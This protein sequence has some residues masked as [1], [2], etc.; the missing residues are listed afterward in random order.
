MSRRYRSRAVVAALAIGALAASVSACDDGT[1]GLPQDNDP[2]A[3]ASTSAADTTPPT[4]TRE[5]AAE[6]IVVGAVP[7]NPG[8]TRAVQAWA[9]DLAADPQRAVE[10][11]WTQPPNRSM[12]GQI[13]AIRSVVAAP[14]V[15]GQYAVTWSDGT[16]SVSAKRSEIASGY[17]CPNVHAASNT[18]FYGPADAEWTLHRYLSRE[19]GRPVDPADTEDRY[20]LV[21]PGNSPWDPESTGAGG[22]PP[23]KADPDSAPRIASFDTDEMTVTPLRGDYMSI[24]VPA[25]DVAGNSGV[26]TAV[27]SIGPDGYCMGELTLAPS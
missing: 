13:E 14:G 22:E 27:L 26:A 21:C 18:D 25:T 24:D 8:A 6:R 19:T 15:D 2:A 9:D 3:S 7:G 16:T 20:P 10:R 12:Y 1:S 17:A 23:L 5:P 4:T 11:C